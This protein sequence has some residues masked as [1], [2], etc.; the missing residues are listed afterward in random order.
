MNDTIVCYWPIIQSGGINKIFSKYIIEL[1]KN[2]KFI[3][4]T[5][6][7][8]QKS[9]NHQLLENQNISFQFTPNI[10][11]LRIIY[12]S[13]FILKYTK[14]TLWA[15][16][17]DALKLAFLLKVFNTRINIYYHERNNP[18][19]FI[20]KKIYFFIIKFANLITVNSNTLYRYL[21][22]NIKR[23]SV[24]LIRIYNPTIPDNEIQTN[25]KFQ[26]SNPQ[27]VIKFLFI[28]RN[29]KQ[30]NLN[31]L[32]KN[33]TIFEELFQKNYSLHIYSNK[34][35]NFKSSN[36]KS[37]LF[38]ENISEIISS[39]DVFINSSIYE[40][41]PNILIEISNYNKLCISS[42][43]KFGYSE[44][45]KLNHFFFFNLEDTQSF[46]DELIKIKKLF[47]MNKKIEINNHKFIEKFYEKNSLKDFSKIINE[48]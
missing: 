1:A 45:Q 33:I 10:K 8:S 20:N 38:T 30:K 21:R 31:F 48:K 17:L 4:I 42:K 37:F 36:I 7:K 18:L 47:L 43:F 29:D 12:A 40:G 24:K 28:G 26:F 34:I 11:F 25:K 2:N 14:K 15:I 27:K 16:Q 13:Y 19:F 39:C 3:L 32:I 6:L 23:K 46:K 41:F 22:R 35:F 44:F 9:I 5:A